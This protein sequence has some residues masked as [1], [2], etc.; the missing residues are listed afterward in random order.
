MIMK[1]WRDDG[2]VSDGE[3]EEKK[4]RRKEGKKD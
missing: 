3:K 4:E 1:F 2:E